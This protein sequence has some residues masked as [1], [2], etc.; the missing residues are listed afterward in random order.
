MPSDLKVTELYGFFEAVLGDDSRVRRTSQVKKNL[1]KS[2]HLQVR[3]PRP[4]VLAEETD[5]WTLTP[6]QA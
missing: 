5:I 6:S 1:L 4:M 3:A 2:E